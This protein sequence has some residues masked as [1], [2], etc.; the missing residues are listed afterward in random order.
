MMSIEEHIEYWIESAD[1]D[2][3]T[4]ESNFVTKH[5]D[6]C[7]FIAH[8]VIEKA[9]KALYVQENDNATPPKIHNLLR[10][11]ELSNIKLTEDQSVFFSLINKFQ[12][13]ARY[14]EYKNELY[15][16]A[17]KDFTEFNLVAIKENYLWLKS[18]I[19]LKK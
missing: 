19:I 4:A 10:L 16:M 14:P 9:L 2:L 1:N 7:L 15:R 3:S 6:W 8:L 5:Y 17:T 12:M 18:L 13:E 11:A